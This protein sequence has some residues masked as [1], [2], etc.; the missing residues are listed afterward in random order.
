MNRAWR[1][2][3]WQ[4]WI[5]T[6]AAGD[7]DYQQGDGDYRPGKK[8]V[9]RVDLRVRHSWTACASSRSKLAISSISQSRKDIAVFIQL[10][11]YHRQVDGD[12]RVM[13]L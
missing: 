7:Q 1:D 3:V 11:I 4:S 12:L 5:P 10:F 2:L 6:A 8:M 13:F 9:R